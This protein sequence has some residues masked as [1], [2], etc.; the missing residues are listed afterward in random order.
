[1]GSLKVSP[2]PFKIA[3]G[4]LPPRPQ[5]LKLEKV[6]DIRLKP[7]KEVVR[8]V[9]QMH[10]AG[11]FMGKDLAEVARIYVDML[12]DKKCTK[13]LSFP[14]APIA[15]GLR[16]VVVDMMKEGMVDVIMTALVVP[17]T[18][19]SHALGPLLPWE[20]RHGRREAAEARLS[21]A[22]EPPRAP[23]HYGPAIERSSSPGS[24]RPTP[25]ERRA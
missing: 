4:A 7:S 6:V 2:E 8:L 12:S 13:F 21:Q 11:G 10:S 25:A 15:T 23:R 9:D 20:L 14:A 1:V 17:W 19:T 3:P 22:R 16:G 18:T 24:R 5:G